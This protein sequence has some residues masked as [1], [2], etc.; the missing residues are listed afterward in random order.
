MFGLA[1][2]NTATIFLYEKLCVPLLVK[3]FNGWYDKRQAKKQGKN[4]KPNQIS[5]QKAIENVA[6]VP[7]AVNQNGQ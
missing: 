2:A 7:N 6:P 5:D 3:C 1:I 4:N